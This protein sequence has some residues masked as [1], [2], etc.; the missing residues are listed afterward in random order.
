MITADMGSLLTSAG[1]L[2]DR[3]RLADDEGSRR[4]SAR[5]RASVVRPLEQTLPRDDGSVTRPGR[6]VPDEAAGSLPE[7]LWALA[8]SATAALA[9]EP[10]CPELAEAAA[11]LQDLAITQA[12]DDTVAAERLAE[13]RALQSGLRPQ[14]QVAAAGPYLVTNARRVLDW[15]GLEQ[16]ARPRVR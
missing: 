4:S 12:A 9:D 1:L 8:R 5:L 10:E 2:A 6:T 11:A 7:E 13:L 15:L 14:I 16:P 3:L